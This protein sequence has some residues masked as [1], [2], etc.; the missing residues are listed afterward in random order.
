MKT[1]FE[2]MTI[3]EALGKMKQ[4]KKQRKNGKKINVIICTIDFDNDIETRKAASPD[5]GCVLIKKSKTLIYNHDEFLPHMELY[6]VIKDINNLKSEGIMHDI[7]W[8]GG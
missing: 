5:E 3:D 2:Y 6:P 8:C 1:S 4:L 7:I